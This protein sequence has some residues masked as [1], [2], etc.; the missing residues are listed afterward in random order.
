MT[1][2]CIPFLLLLVAILVGILITD[3][4][5]QT[6]ETETIVVSIPYASQPGATEVASYLIP[7]QP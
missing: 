2:S 1:R 4:K 3:R 5:A 6:L 7:D